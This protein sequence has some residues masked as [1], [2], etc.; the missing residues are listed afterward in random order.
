MRQADKRFER[1]LVTCSRKFHKVLESVVKLAVD[2]IKP[3]DPQFTIVHQRLR[4]AR[5]TPYSDNCIG[6]IDGTHVPVTVPIE[7]VV[8]YTG[9]KGITT[10]NV[11]TVC[12]FDM[13]FTFVVA[14]WSNSVHDMRVFN[15]TI[16]K[17]GERFPHPP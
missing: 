10:Q 9:R 13:R 15:D 11:L 16:E 14:G 12:D 6:A 7:K 8:Q 4:G 1:S 2:I 3:K 17:Y 5:F